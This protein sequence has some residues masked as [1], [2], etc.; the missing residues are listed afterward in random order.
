MATSEETTWE[1]LSAKAE[2]W[3]HLLWDPN[4]LEK[5][6]ENKR[7]EFVT[8][9]RE[10]RPLLTDSALELCNKFLQFKQSYGS[11]EDK[12]NY[13]SMSTSTFITRLLN[14]RHLVFKEKYHKPLVFDEEGIVISPTPKSTELTTFEN[15]LSA[16]EIAISALVGVSSTTFFSNDGNINKTEIGKN[17]AKG[18]FVALATLKS[19]YTSSKTDSDNE[20]QNKLNIMWD[21]HYKVNEIKSEDRGDHVLQARVRAHATMLLAEANSRAEAL[22]KKAYVHV[23]NPDLETEDMQKIGVSVFLE[24]LDTLKLEKIHVV[25]FANWDHMKKTNQQHILNANYNKLKNKDRTTRYKHHDNQLIVTF[26]DRFYA[27]LISEDNSNDYLLVASYPCDA[28]AYPGNVYWMQTNKRNTT[29]ASTAESRAAGCSFVTTLQNPYVNVNAVRG[30]NVHLVNTE[31][32]NIAKL[33]DLSTVI[34]KMFYQS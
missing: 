18:V 20:E 1:T 5:I 33:W 30:E 29:I 10:T 4:K 28:N 8:H 12:K 23:E 3:D 19:D 26:S 2:K 17:V 14:A 25:A 6:E 31:T 27:T 11:E 9:A 16:D 21:N 7:E 13:R 22:N 24:V 15:N 32:G 34:K